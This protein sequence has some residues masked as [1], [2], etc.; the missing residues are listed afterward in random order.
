[1][2]SMACWDARHTTCRRLEPRASGATWMVQLVL[3]VLLLAGHAPHLT[4]VDVTST[5]PQRIGGWVRR[6]EGGRLGSRSHTT[7]ADKQLCEKL[8]GS[9]HVVESYTLPGLYYSFETCG[10]L[11][12]DPPLPRD[13]QNR[14]FHVVVFEEAPWVFKD[15]EGTRQR[16]TL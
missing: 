15:E 16:W 10:N 2:Q 1:M 4:C 9:R 5:L 11:A 14:T 3:G 6:K 8:C 13:L 12:T 7:C